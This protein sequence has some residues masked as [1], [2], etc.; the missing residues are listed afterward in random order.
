M[1][2]S[3]L[4][5]QLSH[6]CGIESQYQ[7]L[8]GKQHPLS[9]ETRQLLLKAMG[10]RADGQEALSQAL[11]QHQTRPWLRPL[12]P[13]LVFRESHLP[14]IIPITLPNSVKNDNYQWM[15]QEEN[16]PRHQGNFCRTELKTME[17]K[18]LDGKTLVRYAFPLEIK[19]EPGYHTFKIW[20]S[21]KEQGTIN[22]MSFIVAPAGCHLPAELEGDGRAWGLA[23][24]L[25]AL[26]SRRNWGMGDFTDLKNLVDCCP[27]LG[28]GLVGLN[29]L[30]SLFPHNPS[31]ASPYSPSSRCFQ[32]ILY[33][34]VEAIP[35][36]AECET[37][38]KMVLASEFQTK[39]QSLRAKEMVDYIGVAQAKFSV[40]EVLCG[41]FHQHHLTPETQRG[42]EFKEFLSQGG[43][44]LE[45]HAL[46]EV[47]QEHLQKKDPSLW[48]W[49]VWP[50]AYQAPDSPAVKDFLS[51]HSKRV[52]FF[53]YLQWQVDV[54]LKSVN[55]F[56]AEKGLPVGLYQDL[57]VSVDKAGAEAWGN[58]S[59]YALDAGI[60]APPDDFNLLGQDWGLP[61]MIPYQLHEQ[62]YLP[63]INT[64]RSNMRHAGALRIDHIM[65]LT[66]LFWIP[67]GSPPANGTYVRYPLN[68]LMGILALES[69]RNRCM[70][71]GEDLGNVPDDI[72]KAMEEWGGLSYRLFYFEKTDGGNRFKAPPEYPKQALVSITTHDLPT[73]TGFWE[74]RDMEVRNQLELFPDENIKEQKTKEREMDR[75][76]LLEALK[77]ENLL[78]EDVTT[79]P[80]SA[81][82]MT[83]ELS[84]AV[85][86][87]LARTP[88]KLQM[89][90]LEDVLGEKDQINMPGTTT[91]YPNWQ[92]KLTMNLED[93]AKDPRCKKL[94]SVLSRNRGAKSST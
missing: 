31:Q 71:I 94:A 26:R 6:L 74:S 12:E 4:L 82:E 24:Q 22:S 85:H 63:F 23:I 77:G 79:N 78:P 42:K 28:A 33:L 1:E 68:D 45:R 38:R 10:I 86:E 56:C 80:E 46:F 52:D 89:V 35:D 3:Q 16:G 51:T 39:L 29:P 27:E 30:H 11:H 18:K 37:A 13:V 32:N 36:Y 84:S 47:L 7:D 66:R 19:P 8:W 87:F 81:T 70:V 76:R 69:R 83:P 64:L 14:A 62:A 59:L 9:V 2:S 57:A 54:Q 41:H 20:D 88:S 5:N 90:Q 40:L 21:R 65:A 67:R 53:R 72:R 61:P 50:K 92:R 25:Y 93:I 60:G 43:A 75:T 34:D 91:Q 55:R 49:P 15:L 73:L 44:E 58:Q 48:G 17:H